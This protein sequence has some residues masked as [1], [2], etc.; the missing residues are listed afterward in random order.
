MTG[1]RC[2]LDTTIVSDLVRNPSGAVAQ[3]VGQVGSRGIA[4]SILSVVELDYGCAKRGSSRLLRP[5]EAVQVEAVQVEAVPEAID[6]ALVVKQNLRAYLSCK[7][8]ISGEFFHPT[9]DLILRC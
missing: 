2:L 4:T 3:K 1:L 8:S 9:L 7:T 6:V 5:I